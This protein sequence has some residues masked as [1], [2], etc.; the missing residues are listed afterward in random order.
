MANIQDPEEYIRFPVNDTSGEWKPPEQLSHKNNDTK[1][2]IHCNFQVVMPREMLRKWTRQVK[3]RKGRCTEGQEGEGGVGW[4][5]YGMV[6]VDKEGTREVGDRMGED[7]WRDIFLLDNI[8][9]D[10]P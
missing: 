1:K 8:S 4:G 2:L 6:E 3:G 10:Y 5:G 9:M 7:V